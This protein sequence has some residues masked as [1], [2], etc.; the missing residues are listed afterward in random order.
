[1]STRAASPRTGLC[2]RLASRPTLRWAWLWW[3]KTSWVL[4]W[5]PS[6]GEQGRES[7]AWRAGAGAAACSP[8]VSVH[9]S[10][11]ITLPEPPGGPLDLTP[12]LHSLTESLLPKLL[13]QADPQHVIEYSL[14]LIT[15][16]NEVSAGGLPSAGGGRP[17]ALLPTGPLH[18]CEGFVP[19]LPTDKISDLLE[20]TPVLSRPLCGFSPAPGFACPRLPPPPAHL[21]LYPSP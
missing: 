5:S 10:L 12:W 18:S 15:V 16:L 20:M 19:W 6:T 21:F 11:A 4:L 7:R 14:A 3:C 9:R 17:R 1:M 8:V 13:R 2:C